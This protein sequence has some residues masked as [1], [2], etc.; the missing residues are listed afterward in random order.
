MTDILVYWRMKTQSKKKKNL[1][2]TVNLGDFVYFFIW[3][4]KSESSVAC[5]LNPNSPDLFIKYVNW[6]FGGE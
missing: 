6:S 5:N 1:K 2:I 3:G 4:W